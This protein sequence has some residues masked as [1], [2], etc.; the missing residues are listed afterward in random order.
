MHSRSPSRPSR[1][2]GFDDAAPPSAGQTDD[3]ESASLTFLPSAVPHGEGIG[4][5]AIRLGPAVL[6]TPEVALMPAVPRDGDPDDDASRA[7]RAELAL[8]RVEQLLDEMKIY[9]API[10]EEL[11]I[12]LAEDAERDPA[13]PPESLMALLAQLGRCFDCDVMGRD[14]AGRVV[15]SYGGKP[16][17]FV[18][19]W[20]DARA[21]A[22]STPH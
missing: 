11:A 20:L 3:S 17:P 9:R 5:I 16:P 10:A 21:A 6:A 7:A 1:A 22:E 19:A 15:Y 4:S 12:A 13:D 8:A 2:S 18:Q 14:T